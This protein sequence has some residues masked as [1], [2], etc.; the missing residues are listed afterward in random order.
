MTIIDEAHMLKGTNKVC[1]LVESMPLIR[2]AFTGTLPEDSM[3]RWNV[4]GIAGPLLKVTKAKELQKQGYVA[5]IDIVGIC[6]NHNVPQPRKP[7]SEILAEYPD[8]R[9]NGEKIALEIAKARF[10]LEWRCIEDSVKATLFIARL[11]LKLSGNNI[12]LF[13]HIARAP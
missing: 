13:D 12:I 3:D 5:N 8:Y 2:F 4:L 11:A 6:L 7:V 9:S 10:P 1:K